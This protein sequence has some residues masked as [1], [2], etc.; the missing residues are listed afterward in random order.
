MKIIKEVWTK[1]KL[2][3]VSQSLNKKVGDLLDMRVE[4]DSIWNLKRMTIWDLTSNLNK[5]QATIA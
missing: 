5:K 4:L 2:L 1:H 3:G